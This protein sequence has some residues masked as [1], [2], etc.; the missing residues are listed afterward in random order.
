[1]GGLEQG[2]VA[3]GNVI[4]A[5]S[6]WFLAELPSISAFGKAYDFDQA[7]DQWDQILIDQNQILVAQGN[8]E[9]IMIGTTATA[10]L[11]IEGVGYVAAH[12]G[13]S[14]LYKAGQSLD[15]L[16]QD[17]TL[18]ALE[19]ARGAI[20]PAEAMTDPRRNVLLQCIG[21]N[22]ELEPNYFKD[23]STPSG[24]YLICTDGFRHLVSADE[25]HSS[26]TNVV[27][28]DEGTMRECLCY[29]TE[30]NIA[31]GETDNI[32]AILVEVD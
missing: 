16:T 13:D 14:R 30:L 31:R 26:I 17:H 11:L 12:I 7:V 22:D 18:V 21:V 9:G 5:F 10:I 19:L 3:S 32:T 2:E 27:G 8:R 23:L 15:L 28:A 24:Q 4:R 25:I 20:S 29:L 6:D 1:M